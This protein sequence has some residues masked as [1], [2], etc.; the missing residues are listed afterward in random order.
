MNQAIDPKALCKLAVQSLDKHKAVDIRVIRISELSSIADYFVIAE[1]T[2]ST[3]V[4][5]LS[6]YME[7]ELSEQGVQPLHTEGYRGSSWVLL[8]YGCVVVHVF[9]KEARDYYNLEHLWKDG[10]PVPLE[11]FIDVTD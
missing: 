11:E 6:D 1:G 8:D 5:S 3:Q 9:Q 2:S 10:T 4:R 7:T